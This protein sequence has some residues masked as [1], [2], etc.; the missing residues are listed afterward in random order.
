MIE[1]LQDGVGSSANNFAAKGP[2]TSKTVNKICGFLWNAIAGNDGTTLA[3]ACTYKT[4]F[5]VGVHFDI[6]EAIALA[7]NAGAGN[8]LN[9]AENAVSGPSTSGSGIGT[10]GFWLAYWQQSC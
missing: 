1:S 6:G 10:H 7:P 3:T 8:N 4:P 2:A 5:R 9:A